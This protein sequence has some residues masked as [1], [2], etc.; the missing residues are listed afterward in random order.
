MAEEVRRGKSVRVPIKELLAADSPRIKGENDEHVRT[1]AESGVELPPIIVQRGTMRVIDGM[2]RLRAQALRG[3]GYIE[4]VFF[5]GDDTAAYV[6]GVRENISHGLPLSLADRMAAATRIIAF[7]PS[8]SD[9][10][11]AAAAGLS[12]HTVGGLRQR[13]TGRDAQ[14]RNRVGRDGRVRPINSAGGRELAARLIAE[15]PDAS[16]RDIARTAGLSPGTVRDVLAR[17]RRDEDPVPQRLRR[18]A[19]QSGHGRRRGDDDGPAGRIFAQ[20]RALVLRSLRGDP[21]LRLNGV[22]RMLLRLLDVNAV[23]EQEWER[24]IANVPDH[25]KETV[26]ELA[27]GC[28]EMWQKF[29]E[30][31]AA[32]RADGTA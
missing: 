20:E 19:D 16:L 30:R 1:L 31:L 26:L 6:L 32:E 24:I 12:P 8:W 11:I 2:H 21:S 3:A 28:A 9:R 25:C 13:A 4:V 14:L 29:A 15:N 22:G 5:D 23:T 17:I 27:R 18:A 7:Y 10:L